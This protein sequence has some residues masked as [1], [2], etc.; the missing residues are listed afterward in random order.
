LPAAIQT[1]AER[2]GMTLRQFSRWMDQHS[3][4]DVARH[5]AS[6]LEAARPEVDAAKAAGAGSAAVLA[7]MQQLCVMR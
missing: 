6:A 4:A 5:V 2:S 1:P 7:L 3:G